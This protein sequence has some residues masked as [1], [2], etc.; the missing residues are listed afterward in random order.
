MIH[1]MTVYLSGWKL[2]VNMKTAWLF[3][4][5]TS[6]MGSEREAEGNIIYDSNGIQ[7]S[8]TTMGFSFKLSLFINRVV[9]NVKCLKHEF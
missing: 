9:Y 7:I 6:A 5:Y 3:R 2:T 8:G 4:V 1:D